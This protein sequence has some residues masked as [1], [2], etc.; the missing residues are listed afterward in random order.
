MHAIDTSGN[1]G[2][3]FQDTVNPKTVVG[4][5]WLNDYQDNGLNLLAS[6]GITPVKG[7]YTQ[8]AAAL[9]SVGLPGRKAITNLNTLTFSGFFTS[10]STAT[11]RPSGA[12][13][14]MIT[15]IFDK[16]ASADGYQMFAELAADRIWTRRWVSGAWQA[17]AQIAGGTTGAGFDIRPSGVID[18][19]GVV[20]GSG[21]TLAITFPIAFPTACERV[22][23]S[24]VGTSGSTQAVDHSVS[25]GQVLSYDRFGAVIIRSSEDEPSDVFTVPFNGNPITW[26]ARGR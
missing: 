5:D 6:F 24:A 18:Q 25:I 12:A 26:D 19:W 7:N 16:L 20:S 22:L 14:G 15:S 2:G 11:G 3:H 1:S 23:L 13:E 10:S 4:A 9:S 8:L 17:W 21:T